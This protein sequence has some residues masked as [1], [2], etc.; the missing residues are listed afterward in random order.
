MKSM[1]NRRRRRILKKNTPFFRNITTGGFFNAQTKLLIGTS[2]DRYEKEADSVADRIVNDQNN[3]SSSFFESAY[4]TQKNAMMSENS[5]AGNITSLTQGQEEADILTRKS[6]EQDE[7]WND[8]SEEEVLS[9]ESMEEESE[10]EMNLDGEAVLDEEEPLQAKADGS[11]VSAPAAISQLSIHSDSGQKMDKQTQHEMESAFGADFSHVNIHSGEKAAKMNR[12]MGAQAFTHGSDIYFNEGKYN[13]ASRDGKHLLAHELTHTIQQKGKIP[14]NLQFTIGDNHDLTAPRFRGDP[15]LEACYDNEQTLNIGASGPAVSRIQQALID[16]GFP[17][18]KF[19]VDGIFGQ[20]TRQAVI[21]FQR[22]SSLSVDGIIGFSTMSSLNAL[23]TGGSPN[24][25]GI[26]PP[27]PAPAN[28]PVV[29]SETIA[30]AP[31]GSPNTRTTVGV[32]ERV[33]F[34]ADFAGNWSV[35]E[36]RIIGLSTGA[37][38]VWE[39][40]P[41]ASDSTVTLTTA[42]GTQVISMKVIAPDKITMVVVNR[43]NLPAGHA[44]ACMI[45]D[46]TINPLNVNFGRTQWLEVPGPATR[47]SGYFTQF[48]TAQ[49]YHNPTLHYLPINDMNSGVFDHAALHTPPPPYALGTFEWVIP[50]RY[51]IDGESDGHGRMFTHTTQSFYMLYGGV[52]IITKAGASVT[53]L[54]NNIVF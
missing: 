33:R 17:L 52:T 1:I 6:E 40:P 43:H 5:L 20:E 14:L 44:G 22:A 7:I 39:A 19:G 3:G 24:S 28:P 21:S 53:R 37:N 54:I 36:G 11:A 42:G 32:G 25:A 26:V 31:D 18:P 15:V 34:S 4:P 49:L 27:I 47:V 38:M 9:G 10:D 48:S 16:A 51:K 45:N 29:T 30:A 23:F 35:S 50:N 12:E 41:V 13:P 46:L 8:K 2:D